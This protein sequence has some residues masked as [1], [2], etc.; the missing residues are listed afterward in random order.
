MS[1]PLL[2]QLLHSSESTIF[3][4]SASTMTKCCILSAETKEVSVHYADI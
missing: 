3:P 2:V 4:I 1:R